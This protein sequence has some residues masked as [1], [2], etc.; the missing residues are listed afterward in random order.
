MASVGKRGVNVGVEGTGRSDGVA[1]DAGNLHQPAYGVAR[2]AQMVFETHLCG[3]FDLRR[4]AA[5][6]LAGRR[7]SHGARYADLSLTADLGARDRGVGLGDVAEQ[8]GP[9]PTP[10]GCGCARKS[11]EVAKW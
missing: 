8:S 11:R 9:W 6:E 7:G 10:A 2:E 1:L 4:G 5:E 3:I